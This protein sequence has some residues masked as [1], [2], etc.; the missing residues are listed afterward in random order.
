MHLVDLGLVRMRFISSDPEFINN[1]LT[2]SKNL[3]DIRHIQLTLSTSSC[4]WPQ[5]KS[6]SLEQINVFLLHIDQFLRLALDLLI[7]SKV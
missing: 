2:I 7:K 4:R 6:N 5:Q 1:Q 3:S